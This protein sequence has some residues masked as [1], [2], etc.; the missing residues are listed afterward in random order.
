MVDGSSQNLLLI[1][2]AVLLLCVLLNNNNMIGSCG[3][4]MVSD[5]KT[6]HYDG[7]VP[8]Q[9]K[10]KAIS[11]D[12]IPQE[13]TTGNIPASSA[14][15]TIV[16]MP[17]QAQPPN[18]LEYGDSGID[19]WTQ[20]FNDDLRGLDQQV[21][22]APNQEPVKNNSNFPDQQGNA[23]GNSVNGQ[24]IDD[25]INQRRQKE[26]ELDSAQLMPKEINN[27]W[28]QTDFSDAKFRLGG[29]N[30]LPIDYYTIGVDTIQ[31]SLKNPSYDF[32]GDI[33]IPKV[34][35]SPWNQ[36]TIDPDFNIKGLGCSY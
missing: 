23:M 31:Q 15:S 1:V 29:A 24:T 21:D 26:L 4:P 22:F 36:S 12:L 8:D 10:S 13:T 19:K 35:V 5:K 28:F 3:R 27:D 25:T 9:L 20:M 14:D 30:L 16:Q 33:P 34:T 2:F 18:A 17:V 11:N 7:N 6:E 32:R